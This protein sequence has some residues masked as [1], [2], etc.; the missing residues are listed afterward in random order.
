VGLFRRI[1]QQRE[2]QILSH[3]E[4]YLGEGEEVVHWVRARNFEGRRS[5]G[6]LFI[7]RSRVILV[8]TVGKGDDAHSEWHE[9]EAWGVNPEL[10]GGPVLA[11]ECVGTDI[12][13]RLPVSTTATAQEV[14]NFLR[15]FASHAPTPRR[16][17]KPKS[18]HG[19]FHSHAEVKVQP[20][21]RSVTDHTKRILVTLLGVVLVVGGIL[22][23][24]LPGPWS[25]PIIVGGLAVLAT[26][27]DW[28]D[29][30][31]DWIKK[32][33]KQLADKVRNRRKPDG[34]SPRTPSS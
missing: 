29:D 30:M 2:A 13:A 27:Y 34:P 8:W 7:T 25:F 5:R 26:E 18:E 21:K 32:R 28:A 33:S 14:R 3:A 12:S 22:I 1:A 15:S 19:P 10:D 16:T 24:P 11:V 6:F 9:I 17:L 23:T 31:R 20:A 4:P